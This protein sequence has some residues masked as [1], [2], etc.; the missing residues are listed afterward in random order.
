M[1]I[2]VQRETRKPL[3]Q[4]IALELFRICE[5]D[6]DEMKMLACKRYDPLTNDYYLLFKDGLIYIQ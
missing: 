1:K 4:D 5:Y 6:F 3:L 2:T